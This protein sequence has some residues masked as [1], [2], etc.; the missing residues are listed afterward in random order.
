MP[1][2][3]K[4]RENNLSFLVNGSEIME[5]YI[6]VILSRTLTIPGKVIRK[7]TGDEYSHASI[8]LD[9]DLN[10]MYSFARLRYQTPMIGG[11]VRENVQ[12]LSLGKEQEVMIKIFRIPVTNKQYRKISDTIEYFKKNEEKYLYNLF[13]LILFLAGIQFPIRDSYI[14]TE[15]VTQLLRENNIQAKYFQNRRITPM[16]IIKALQKYE[17]Y[18]GSLQEYVATVEHEEFETK[19]FERENLAFVVGKSI[20]QVGRLLYRKIT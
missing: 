1:V 15:F 13:G 12:S 2:K 18:Q 5:K 19:F 20:R 4:T 7:I 3:N 11:F 14:C 8:S 10:E 6:Y 16:K 9:K 17:Y